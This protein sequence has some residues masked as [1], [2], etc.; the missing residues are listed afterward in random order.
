MFNEV[1]TRHLVV[2]GQTGSSGQELSHV[3]FAGEQSRGK[4]V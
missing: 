4:F 1:E 2:A 3:S